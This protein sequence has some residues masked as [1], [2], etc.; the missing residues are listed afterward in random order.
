MSSLLDHDIPFLTILHKAE[1]TERI[2]PVILPNEVQSHWGLVVSMVVR[3]CHDTKKNGLKIT[4]EVTLG[5]SFSLVVRA[6]AG[7]EWGE[8]DSLDA[9]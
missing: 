3:V 4:V 6:T 5:I 7:G 9:I 8:G 1:N 2:E